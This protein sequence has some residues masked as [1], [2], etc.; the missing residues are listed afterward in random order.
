LVACLPLL[1]RKKMKPPPVQVG[2]MFAGTIARIETYGAFCALK[3]PQ[4]H[5]Q[6]QQHQHHQQQGLIHI[7]QG[8][9]SRT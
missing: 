3:Q 8:D 7:S 2:D 6:Q 4:Q 9:T 1:K 5:H